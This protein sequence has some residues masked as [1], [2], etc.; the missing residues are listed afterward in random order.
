MDD[1]IARR[2]RERRGIRDGSDRIARIGRWLA[3]KP[4]SASVT[5]LVLS[6]EDGDVLGRWPVDRVTVH[7]AMDINALILD[8][9][10]DAGTTIGAKLTWMRDGESP[11]LSKGFRAKCD[12][13]D[14]ENVR[15]LDGTMT[16]FLSQSQRHTEALASQVAQFCSNSEA[17]VERFLAIQE[18][19]LEKVLDQLDVS[20]RRRL[21]AEHAEQEALDLANQAT[22]AG[23]QAAMAAEAAKDEKDPMGQ[24]I[25]ITAKQ[26]LSAK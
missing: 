11:Y 20:E 18:R 14:R 7:M 3:A 17:R 23:E 25:E 1:D 16:S 5:E 12:D 13:E 10:N 22:E 19:M 15:P 2:G 24:I 9:A 6:L 26:L 4:V 8:A 21:A